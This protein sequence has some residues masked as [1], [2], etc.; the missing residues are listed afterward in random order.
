MGM[1]MRVSTRAR[2]GLGF[3]PFSQ[4]MSQAAMRKP[5]MNPPVGPANS[6]KPPR[7]P[8]Y[9]GTPTAPNKIHR[10]TVT[11]ACSLVSSSATRFRTKVWAV[12]L[13]RVMGM[14]KAI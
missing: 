1:P 8:E 13:T 9:T 6:L 10:A 2:R 11:P 5:T 4:A 14:G 12:T 7:P 3:S